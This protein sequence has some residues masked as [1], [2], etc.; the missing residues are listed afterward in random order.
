MRNDADQSLLFGSDAERSRNPGMEEASR[1]LMA[2]F[3]AFARTGESQP[4]RDAYEILDGPLFTY[5]E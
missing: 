1:N 5:S 4:F 2:V 3:D